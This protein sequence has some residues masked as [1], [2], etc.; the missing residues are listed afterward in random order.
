MVSLPSASRLLG[1]AL[2]LVPSAL[3]LS[4]A[5]YFVHNLPGAPA[6]PP[7]KMHAG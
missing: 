2:A 6:E 3:A 5:D 7:I 4:A 1:A